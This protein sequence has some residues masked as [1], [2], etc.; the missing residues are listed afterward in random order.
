MGIGIGIGIGKTGK[1]EAAGIYIT[2][3]M[4]PFYIQDIEGGLSKTVQTIGVKVIKMPDEITVVRKFDEI[5]SKC[6]ISLDGESF[7]S[8]VVLPINY[9]GLLYIKFLD[10]E[11]GLYDI[12][13]DFKINDEIV[14]EVTA[15]GYIGDN[16]EDNPLPVCD[17]ATFDKIRELREASHYIYADI[18]V[19]GIAFTPLGMQSQEF[20]GSLITD[21]KIVKNITINMPNDDNIG[22]FSYTIGATFKNIRI[23]NA[24]IIC[25]RMSGGFVALPSESSFENCH[26][27]GT[28]RCHSNCGGFSHYSASNQYKNC[29]ADIV[30][31]LE[32]GSFSGFVDY[33]VLDTVNECNAKLIA[34]SKGAGTSL[35]GFNG[36]SEGS[37]FTNCYATGHIKK[38]GQFSAGFM[39]MAMAELGSQQKTEATNCYSAVKLDY[40]M[41]NPTIDDLGGFVQFIDVDLQEEP[42]GIFTDCFYD[43][44]YEGIDFS[45]AGTAKTTAQMKDQ[46]TFTNWDFENAVGIWKIP[47]NR[48]PQLNHYLERDW[49]ELSLLDKIVQGNLTDTI[50][51]LETF[52][53]IP[54][55]YCG[56]KVN[57][58]PKLVADYS[59][60][61]FAAMGITDIK[62]CI[63]RDFEHSGMPEIFGLVDV[64]SVIATIKGIKYP[65]KYL[66]VTAHHDSIENYS[67]EYPDN[68]APGADDNGSGMAIM[69]EI[70]RIIMESG[71]RPEYSIRFCSFGGEE[72]GTAGSKFYMDK[73]I[74]PNDTPIACINIDMVGTDIREEAN[75]LLKVIQYT[76]SDPG[77]KFNKGVRNIFEQK[78]DLNTTTPVPTNVGSDATSFDEKGIPSVWIHEDLKSAF[79]HTEDDLR[80]N[81]NI[82]YLMKVAKGALWSVLYYSKRIA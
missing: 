11:N 63:N 72:T 29:S 66:Y 52:N 27:S 10:E 53:A 70:A 26:I 60:Q 73:Y 74:T 45:A 8:P 76:A 49:F 79:Y 36:T 43:S 67:T 62:Y 59:A 20:V 82:P 78:A 7:D 1:Q 19:A 3:E 58:S 57:D 14:K 71:F 6:G 33:S 47:T 50:T 12:G 25:N 32:A 44:E 13:I 23:E 5:Y 46:A 56:Y 16:T 24:N 15:K 48:Y 75:W 51:A 37:I 35:V 31:L 22:V 61:R 77:A 2:N 38:A 69:F 55:R 4:T 28:M 41:E 42:A 30:A 17:P 18:D 39:Y 54:T 81:M 80:E 64:I 68:P 9:N 40:T 34:D 65:T 21:N